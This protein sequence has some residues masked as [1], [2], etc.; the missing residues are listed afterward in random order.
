MRIRFLGMAAVALSSLVGMAGLAEAQTSNARSNAPATSSKVPRTPWGD[1][2][3]QGTWDYRTITPLERAREF[4]TREFYTEA[5]KK[6]LEDRAGR[7]MDTVPEKITP[8]LNHAQWWT[9]PGRF[10][11]DCS[12]TSLIVDP[13][14]GRSPPLTAEGRARQGRAPNPDEARQPPW[15]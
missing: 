9:D 11:S 2:D 1:P 5:E 3:L 14:D 13:P 12:R 10:V 7:R 4:G 6:A 15:A 8:G